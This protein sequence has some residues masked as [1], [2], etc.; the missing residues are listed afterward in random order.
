MPHVSAT[1]PATRLELGQ[2]LALVAERGYATVYGE[3]DPEIASIAAPVFDHM[4]AIA[5]SVSLSGPHFRYTPEHVTELVALLLD[6]S[7]RISLGLGWREGSASA[8]A[9]ADPTT[10]QPL[11]MTTDTME[12]HN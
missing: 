11:T 6:G 10:A 2:R 9:A 5:A 4:G 3:S 12:Q 1:A 8:V 7:R